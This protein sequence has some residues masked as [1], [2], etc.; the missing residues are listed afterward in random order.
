MATTTE[1]GTRRVPL[2]DDDPSV[3]ARAAEPALIAREQCWADPA[4]LPLACGAAL[5]GVTVA[6]ET[7]GRLNTAGTNAVL[8]CHALT[9]DAHAAGR[10]P[11]ST[12]AG[13]WDGLIGPGRAVDTDRYFVICSNVLGG[14]RGTTG[15]STPTPTTGV[16]Y[17]SAFPQVT[18]RDMVRLQAR[19]LA[20]LGVRQVAAVIGGSLGGMQ[21]LEWITS[22]PGLVRGAV[23]IGSAL[24][25]PAQGIAYNLI[26][27]EAIMRDP[28]WQG[29]DYYGTGRTPD[30]GLALARMIGMITYQSAESMRRKF[31]RA[32]VEPDPESYYDPDARFQVEN[33]LHYQGD[34]LVQRFDA[35]SYLVLSRAMD[36]HDVG[37]GRGGTA[38]ALAGVHPTARLLAIG[39][40]SDILFPTGLQ[41]QIVAAFRAAGRAARYAE[42]HSA[43]GHDAFLI[44]H[45]Q[46][47]GMVGDFLAEGRDGD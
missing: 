7:C 9:G 31:D 30:A 4:P 11:D 25:H 33:Y 8:I 20:A 10:Y 43:W 27:R 41:R 13:W 37:H 44:E 35:N 14:C 19:L 29:G 40:D 15:P 38:A 47:G 23:S 21:V 39:I 32:R 12:R 3:A 17:G 42:I 16:P 26:G 6:Y 18:V 36:L 45:A 34:S 22:Y 5:H 1:S 46:L 24:A 2:L 28:A